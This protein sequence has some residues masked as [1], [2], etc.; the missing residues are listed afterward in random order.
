MPWPSPAGCCAPGL[1]GDVRGGLCCEDPTFLVG[2]DRII[3][4]LQPQ[5]RSPHAA[6]A[7][8]PV[9]L[10]LHSLQWNVLACVEPHVVSY[11]M[12]I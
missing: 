12:T 2:A 9:W 7:F 11:A 8:G 6:V 3:P 1:Q 5:L 10:Q 4:S